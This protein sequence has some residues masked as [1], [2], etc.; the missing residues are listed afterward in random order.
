MLVSFHGGGDWVSG[1]AL[2]AISI[3]LMQHDII[4]ISIKKSGLPKFI[5]TALLSGYISMLLTGVFLIV[6]TNQV[7]AYDAILHTFFLGFVFS[8]IFAHGPVI[9]PGVLGIAVKPYHNVLYLWL[10]LLHA[11]WITRIAA[12]VLLHFDLRKMSGL[13]SAV[14][15]LGYFATLAT[16]V[17]KQH[18][19]AEIL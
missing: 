13:L 2:I 5:A 18:R 17:V 8:M 4:G 1:M 19:H 10:F 11:S 3:W 9:L 16:L 15:I 14:C 6:F 7:L 12:D